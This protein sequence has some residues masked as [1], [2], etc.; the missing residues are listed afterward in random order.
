MFDNKVAIVTGSGNGIGREIALLLA[1]KG[2][3][4]VVNDLG[5]S[6]VGEGAS[7][8]PAEETAAM[9]RAAGGEAA[10]STDSV[11]DWK[12]AHRIVETALDAFGKVDIVINNAGNLRWKPFWEVDAEEFDAIVKTHLYG[13]FNVSRAAAPHFKERGSGVYV[14]TTSTSGLIGH[15]DQA[16]Y[17]AAKAGIVGLS[18]AIALEMKA[19]NVRSNCVAPFANSRMA[20]GVV[21]SPEAMKALQALTPAQNA[22]LAVALASDA[23]K[24]VNGQVFISRG[25]EILLTHQGLP[26]NSVRRAAGWTPETILSEAMPAMQHDFTPL[27]GFGEL[28]TWPAV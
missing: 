25:N 3:K 28:F 13:T 6:V 12:S 27:I 17:C 5:G 4:V 18:K 20:A 16:H 23:A 26:K 21:K 8:A 1:A 2:A 22:Q 19:F 11:S 24:H 15:Y 10:V 7:S 14:H 9:I